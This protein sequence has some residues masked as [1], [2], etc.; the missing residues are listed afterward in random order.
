MSDDGLAMALYLIE[1][2]Q[3]EGAERLD[4]GGCGLTSLPEELFALTTLTHLSL[5]ANQ[6]TSLSADIGRLA[7]LTQLSVADNQLQELPATLGHLTQLTHLNLKNNQLTVLPFEICELEQ[8][9]M[10]QLQGNPLPIPAELLA[11]WDRPAAVIDYY[12]QNY[13]TAVEDK[14]LQTATLHWLIA[15]QFDEA[16]LRWLCEEICVPYDELAGETHSQKA[17]ALVDF[18]EQHEL[19]TE[20]TFLLRAMRPKPFAKI[21]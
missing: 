8:L 2:A 9:E 20:F 11:K 5:R 4:L 1:E 14:P 6:L 19:M 13:L 21:G 18:H 10:L 7:A 17:H 12:R 16:E 15:E 3:A